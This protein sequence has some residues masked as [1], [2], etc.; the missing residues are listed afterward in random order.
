[1][2]NFKKVKIM[3]TTQKNVKVQHIHYAVPDIKN[4]ETYL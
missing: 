3:I 2:K 4:K 1:M